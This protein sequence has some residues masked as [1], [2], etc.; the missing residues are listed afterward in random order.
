[1]KILSY[2]SDYWRCTWIEE[3]NG[4]KYLIF[5]SADINKKTLEKYINLK[6]LN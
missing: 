1:M 4:Y 2:I 6:I 3:N 5:T